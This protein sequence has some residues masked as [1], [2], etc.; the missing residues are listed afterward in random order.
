MNEENT[1]SPLV[2][3]LIPLYN[4]ENYI[5]ETIESALG[6][7]YR[8]KEIIIVDDGSTDAGPTLARSY[9]KHGVTVISQKNQGQ[10]AAYNTALAASQG[11]YIQY[12]DADDILHPGKIAAQIKRLASEPIRTMASGPWGRFT[13]SPEESPMITEPV[14]SDLDPIDWLVT[15]WNGGGMMHVAGWLIPRDVVEAAGPWVPAFRYAPNIDGDFFTK[16]LLSSTGCVFCA[17]A[18]SYYRKVPGSQSSRI[19]RV[20]MESALAV[21]RSMGEAL[22]LT[23]NSVR[24]R[25]AYA[26]NLQR[27]VYQIFPTHMD[28]VKD[29]ELQIKNLGGSSITPSFGRATQMASRFVGWKLARKARQLIG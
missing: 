19:D 27:F 11:Q 26:N 4:C 17:D 10:S 1:V 13:T 23:E 16:A 25:L 3:I 7:T 12:L 15:S 8:R 22:L 20:S 29:V 5:S 21:L 14:W 2:S 24:T 6:Q 9:A 28:M 18:P